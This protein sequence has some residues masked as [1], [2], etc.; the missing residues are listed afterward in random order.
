MIL[1]TTA[2]DSE[3]MRRQCRAAGMDD[4]VLKPYDETTVRHCLMRVFARR[5][6][7]AEPPEPEAPKKPDNEVSLRAFAQSHRPVV[8]AG[9]TLT[10]V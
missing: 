5:A 4:F 9:R 10:T 3:E 7:N 1:A 6:G 8:G 2:H